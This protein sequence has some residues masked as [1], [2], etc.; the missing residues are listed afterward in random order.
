M[1]AFSLGV[2]LSLNAGHY[3]EGISWSSLC[4]DQGCICV[5]C[6]H[7]AASLFVD[8]QYPPIQEGDQQW[9]RLI[10][11]VKIVLVRMLANVSVENSTRLLNVKVNVGSVKRYWNQAREEKLGIQWLRLQNVVDRVKSKSA[12]I[13]FSTFQA[14][15]LK[16]YPLKDRTLTSSSRSFCSLF[17]S[18]RFA[19]SVLASR[20]RSVITMHAQFARRKV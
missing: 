15:R 19:I 1:S 7:C 18:V 20:T 4:R 2:E 9:I 14:L 12:A 11:P 17:G 16:L 3:C 13:K 10:L 5:K 8:G 6:P